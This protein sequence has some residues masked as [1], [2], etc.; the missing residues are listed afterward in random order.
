MGRPSSGASRSATSLSD[1]FLDEGEGQGA[2]LLRYED[3]VGDPGTLK[4]LA[5]H[6]GSRVDEEVLV[7]RLGGSKGRAAVGIGARLLCATRHRALMARLGYQAR[8][9][10]GE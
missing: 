6:L 3:L 5:E 9:A 8:W 1:S 10:G 7:A 4:T 2:L